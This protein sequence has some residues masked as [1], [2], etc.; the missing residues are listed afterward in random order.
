MTL[1]VTHSIREL[2]SS[3]AQFVQPCHMQM[4]T[5]HM[6]LMR[7]CGSTAMLQR[8]SLLH[9]STISIQ[10]PIMPLLITCPAAKLHSYHSSHSP[11]SFVL[12]PD[13]GATVEAS[14]VLGQRSSSA[15][16]NLLRSTPRATTSRLRLVPERSRLRV[17]PDLDSDLAFAP[18]LVLLH[19]H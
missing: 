15:S 11:K 13:L 5:K 7:A 17:L 12:C 10:K 4:L 9:G 14:E 16:E 1:S 18:G 6:L 3:I 19:V 8:P 2:C